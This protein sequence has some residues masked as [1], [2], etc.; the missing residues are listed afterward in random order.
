MSFVRWQAEESHRFTDF[1]GFSPVF[2]FLL[3]LVPHPLHGVS[4][5]DDWSS[6]LWRIIKENK[7]SKR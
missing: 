4:H 7:T 3:I 5:V 1:L 6:S 2:F